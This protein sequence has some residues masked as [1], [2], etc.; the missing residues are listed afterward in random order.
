[1]T[2]E[3]RLRRQAERGDRARAILEDELTQDAFKAIE[4]QLFDEWCAT[5]PEETEKREQIYRLHLSHLDY[6]QMLAGAMG[7]GKAAVT[8]LKEKGLLR[9]LTGG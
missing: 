5:K 9:R 4:R 1:M 8:Q 7:T 6:R 2:D 3:S